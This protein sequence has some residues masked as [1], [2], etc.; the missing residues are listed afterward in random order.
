MQPFYSLMNVDL[1][2][3]TWLVKDRVD[4]RMRGAFLVAENSGAA[5]LDRIRWVFCWC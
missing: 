4:G 5:C 2:L 3:N 1:C